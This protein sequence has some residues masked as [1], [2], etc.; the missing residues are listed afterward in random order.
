MFGNLDDMTKIS[1]ARSRSVSPENVYGAPGRGGMAEVSDTPQPEVA[2]LGQ[3][4]RRSYYARELGQTWKVRPCIALDPGSVTTLMD[5]SGPGCIRHIWMTVHEKYLRSLVLRMYW[6]GEAFPSVEAPLGD[7]FCNAFKH[8]A[9]VRAIPVNV[10]PRNGMNCYFPMPFAKQAKITI[11]NL[12]PDEEIPE[13]FYTFN[14]EE[15]DEPLNAGYF[16]ARFTRVNPL[17]YQEDFVILDDVAGSGNF[18]GCYLVWQ[19]NN[20]GW[21]GEGEVKM[22]LDDDDEFPSICGTGTEDYFGGAWGFK[23]V[24]TAPFVGYPFGVEGPGKTGAR[25]TLY[26]FHVLDPIHFHTRFRATIQ[27]LGWRDKGRFLPLRD[28]ISAVAF[29]YQ[30]E[31]HRPYPEFYDR[32]A[33][34]II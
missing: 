20:D 29:F 9:E 7:F 1:R 12:L 21:W 4:W 3:K 31:P 32:N 6:D 8:N 34:E 5:V 30:V 13:L 16:H 24:F 27:A 33:L 28:D 18:V 2:R 17:P 14:F 15:L 11:E 10:N 22:Y 23:Q 25:H 26:R 19:Q